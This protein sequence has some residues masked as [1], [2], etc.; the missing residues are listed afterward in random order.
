M[1]VCALSIVILV[2]MILYMS[3]YNALVVLIMIT[4]YGKINVQSNVHL[5]LIL[6]NQYNTLLISRFKLLEECA[7]IP[8]LC[9]LWS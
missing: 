7:L 8:A 4:T 2:F 1:S 3:K 5:V 9:K 6:M